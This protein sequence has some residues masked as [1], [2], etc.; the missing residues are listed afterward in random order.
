M[1][2]LVRQIAFSIA[3]L[4]AMADQQAALADDL[5]TDSAADA[6][7][8][9]AQHHRRRADELRSELA[10][11]GSEFAAESTPTPAASL[12]ACAR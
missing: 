8:Q 7:R 11:L 5:D 2:G 4:E 1:L 9:V 6:I 12:G 10:S 3:E